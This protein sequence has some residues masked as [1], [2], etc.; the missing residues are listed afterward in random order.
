MV[1]LNQFYSG[2]T[3]PLQ[4]FPWSE[5]IYWK[6]TSIRNNSPS[7]LNAFPSKEFMLDFEKLVNQKDIWINFSNVLQKVLPL[8]S[9][10]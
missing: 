6:I 8:Q 3:L 2:I 10:F 7:S 5:V 1:K 4:V 9:V